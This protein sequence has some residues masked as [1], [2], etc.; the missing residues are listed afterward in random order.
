MVYPQK[1]NWSGRGRLAGFAVICV[2][3]VRTDASIL[4]HLVHPS[5]LRSL[6][7]EVAVVFAD[8]SGLKHLWQVAAASASA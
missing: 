4:G 2:G 3:R 5:W 7:T 8:E 1:G 6:Q